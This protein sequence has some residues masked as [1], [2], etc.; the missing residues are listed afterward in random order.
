M[1]SFE[2]FQAY[3]KFSYMLLVGLMVR[4]AFF[5]NPIYDF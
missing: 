4:N 3:L 2:E 1:I 5:N